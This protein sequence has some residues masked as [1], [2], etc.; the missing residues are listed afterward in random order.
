[1]RYQYELLEII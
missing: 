1:M